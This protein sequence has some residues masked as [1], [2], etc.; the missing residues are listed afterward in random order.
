MKTSGRLVL[1]LAS[2]LSAAS[3]KSDGRNPATVPVVPAPGFRATPSPSN[4][5]WVSAN[6]WTPH[7][8]LADGVQKGKA[9]NPAA[10]AALAKPADSCQPVHYGCNSCCAD[11]V[12]GNLF[13]RAD[14]TQGCAKDCGSE[15]CH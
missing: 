5:T 1:C 3:C 14:C 4:G 11:G 2:L 12:S 15:P 13:V 9:R 6:H 7:P 8:S 10:L